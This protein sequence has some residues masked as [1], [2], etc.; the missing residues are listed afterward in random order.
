MQQLPRAPAAHAQRVCDPGKQR[1]KRQQQNAHQVPLARCSSQVSI[2]HTQKQAKMHIHLSLA[3]AR[4]TTS[5]A[6]YFSCMAGRHAGWHSGAQ[7]QPWA[8]ALLPAADRSV[9]LPLD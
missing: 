2:L 9:C 4:N 1:I 5:C 8:A 7:Q 3:Q 6:R